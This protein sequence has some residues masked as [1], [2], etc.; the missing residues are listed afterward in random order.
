MLVRNGE[1]VDICSLFSLRRHL[2]LFDAIMRRYI[3]Y[4]VIDKKHIAITTKNNANNIIYQNINIKI[5]H[6]VKDYNFKC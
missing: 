6:K 2:L 1:M 3:A 4:T 5:T